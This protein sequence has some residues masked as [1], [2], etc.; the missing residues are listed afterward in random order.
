MRPAHR[1]ANVLE[2][3]GFQRQTV[4]RTEAGDRHQD[5]EESRQKRGSENQVADQEAIDAEER[6]PDAGGLRAQLEEQ[7][8]Q[9]LQLIDGEDA[10]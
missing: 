7:Q 9:R 3:V 5:A 1:H 6:Q 4:A 8:G 2:A 10:Q